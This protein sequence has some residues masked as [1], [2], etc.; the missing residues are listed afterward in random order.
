ML[1]PVLSM[2]PLVYSTLPLPVNEMFMIYPNPVNDILIMEVKEYIPGND[3][4]F[5]LSDI[6]GRLIF[7]GVL[8]ETKIM[9]VSGLKN[10]MYV[11]TLGN[12][13]GK[14]LNSYKVVK[15]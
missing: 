12:K 7:S 14:I 5:Y 13:S 1:R 8:D 15:Y 11:L 3:L 10:G 2:K 4:Y 9:D 6:S